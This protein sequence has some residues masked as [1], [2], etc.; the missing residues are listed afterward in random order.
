MNYYFAKSILLIIAATAATTVSADIAGV[1]K[2]TESFND[3]LGHYTHDTVSDSTDT[4]SY[5]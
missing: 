1:A 5:D 3:A 4:D 2:S